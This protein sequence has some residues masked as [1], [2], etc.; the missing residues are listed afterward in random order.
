M[1][2]HFF[3]VMHALGC[4]SCAASTYS[5][6]QDL[7]AR[8]ERLIKKDIWVLLSLIPLHFL[9]FQCEGALGPSS[10]ALIDAALVLR[11][12][13][14]KKSKNMGTTPARLLCDMCALFDPS[15]TE[16]RPDQTWCIHNIGR[17]NY[18]GF[19]YTLLLQSKS[20]VVK[21]IRVQGVTNEA[22]SAQLDPQ[23]EHGS[24]APA[25]T[26]TSGSS[27]SVITV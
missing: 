26:G 17:G 8:E 12:C 16:I 5:P 18:V 2:L 3:N 25:A 4:V 19:Y 23:K 14:R 6:I 9:E 11:C 7:K 20:E 27:P 10:L 13:L 24:C 1:L 15:K 22:E 21:C